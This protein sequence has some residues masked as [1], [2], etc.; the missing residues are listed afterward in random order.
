M[1]FEDLSIV[2]T[3]VIIS[4]FKA[5]YTAFVAEMSAGLDFEIA[6]SLTDADIHWRKSL[7]VTFFKRCDR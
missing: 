6:K 5:E 1:I 2:S 4:A 7:I 3:K